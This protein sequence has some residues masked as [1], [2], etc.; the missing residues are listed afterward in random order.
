MYTLA[1]KPYLLGFDYGV[2]LFFDALDE[3]SRRLKEE[4]FESIRKFLLEKVSLMNEPQYRLTSFEK[5]EMQAI[6]DSLF[7]I[8]EQLQDEEE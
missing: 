8:K 5:E 1:N 2:A 6:V 3:S 4:R 7:A